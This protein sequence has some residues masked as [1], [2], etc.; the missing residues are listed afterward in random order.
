MIDFTENEKVKLIKFRKTKLLK[1]FNASLKAETFITRDF[2]AWLIL[3]KKTIKE[4]LWDIL[5]KNSNKAD[6]ENNDYNKLREEMQSALTTI[7]SLK[8]NKE[9]EFIVL[10]KD[11]N[12][13][14]NEV[15][16]LY[17]I[18]LPELEK[19]YTNKDF[20]NYDWLRR[21]ALFEKN[22]EENEFIKQQNDSFIEILKQYDR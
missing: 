4:K 20:E 11:L 12:D 3:E 15:T 9:G 10:K 5:R 8:E 6:K 14:W 19:G 7:A 13:K 22:K 17:G 2:E 21:I 1:W 16:E 18:I